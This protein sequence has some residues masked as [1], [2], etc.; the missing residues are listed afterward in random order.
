[1][2]SVLL[3]KKCIENMVSDEFKNYFEIRTHSA[4]TRNN[5]YLLQIPKV[6][7]QF[8]KAGFFSMSV[9]SF[10]SLPIEIRQANSYLDFRNLSKDYFTSKL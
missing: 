7:L 5:G 1:M 9:K 3:V 2:H 8:A 4:A 10:N 6:K